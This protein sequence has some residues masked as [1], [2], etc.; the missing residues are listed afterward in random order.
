MEETD[1]LAVL[2]GHNSTLDVDQSQSD[3]LTESENESEPEYTDP[4]GFAEQE[5]NKITLNNYLNNHDQN[6]T[7]NHEENQQSNAIIDRAREYQQELFEK[8]RDENVIAVLD[9][10]SGKTLIAALLIRH[11]L[12]QEL[13]D[14]SRGKSPKIVFFLVNSVHLARQQARFLSNNLPQKVIPLFGDASDALWE[15]AEWDKIFAENGVVVCTAAV[16]DS[17]LMHSYL[18]V[19][20]ISLLVFDEAHHCKKNHPYSR[21]IRDY[22]LKWRGDK[23]RIFGMTASPVDSR[24]DISKVAEDLETLLQS[25]IVTTNDLSVFDFAPRAKDV[26]WIYPPLEAEFET[27]LYSQLKPLCGSFQEFEPYFR[28]ARTASRQLGAWA[29]DRLWQYAFPT[30]EYESTLIL[31][32]FERSKAYTDITENK[33]RGAALDSLREAFSIVQK[34]S[35]E[36]PEVG[37]DRDLSSKVQKLY[38]ELKTRFSHAAT[39]RSIVFVEER[40]TALILC[41]LFESLSLP[42]LRA[43]VLM[44]ITSASDLKSSWKDQE[45]VMEKFR[46]GIINIIFATSVAE[47]GIDIP[48]CNLVIRFDLYRTPIQYMQSRG[49]ARMKGSIFVHMIEEGNQSQEADVNFA[50]DQDEYI[51]KFCQ[52][53]PPDRLLGQGSKL[54]QLMAKDANCRS[55]ETSSGV[56]ANY[57]N[58]LL[59]LSRYA[60]SLKK[61]GAVSS[62]IYEE[63]ID[64]EENMF[65]YRVIL[66]ITD[67]ERTAQVKGAKGEARSNK[68]LAKRSAAWHCLLKLR[69]AHLLDENLNSIFFKAKPANHN[70]KTAVPE[71]KEQYDKKVKP[72]FWIESGATSAMLPTNLFVTHVTVGPKSPSWCTDGLLLL[73]RTPLPDIP[74]FSVFVDDNVEKHVQFSRFIG[75][76][77]VT[78]DQVGALTTFTLRGVFHDFFNKVYAQTSTSMSYWLAPPAKGEMKESFESIVDVD[79]LL[80]AQLQERHRWKSSTSAAEAGQNAEKWC[81]AFVVDPGS[82][83]YRYFTSN[84]LPGKSIWDP[85]PESAKSAQKSTKNTIIEFSDSTWGVRRKH[86]Q[87]IAKMYDSNQPVLNAKVVIAGRNFL[88]ECPKERTRYAMCHIAPQPLELGRISFSVAQTCLLWPSILRRLESYLIVQE[89][90]EK[91]DLSGVPLDLALEAYTQEDHTRAD[92]TETEALILE[93]QDVEAQLGKEEPRAVMNYQRLEF[94]GDSLLKMMTTITVFNRSTC[95]EEGMHCKRMNLLSNNRLCTTASA[96]HYEL[97]RYIRSPDVHWRDTWYPEFLELEKGRLIKV[98][99]KHRKHALGKKTIADVCEAT[100]GACIMSTRHLPTEE[101]FDLGIKAITKL[102]EHSDHA[103]NSWKEILPMY[104]PASWVAELNDPIANDIADKLFTAT[105]YR[106]K[107][108]RLAR[109]AFTHSSD[110]HSPVQNLQRLEFLGDACL[111]WVCIWW[112]FSTNPTRGPQWLTEHKMAMVSNK[113]LAALAVVLGF[114]KLVYANSMGVYDDIARYASKVQEAWEQ[115]DVRADFWTRI[116]EGHVPKVLA[117]LVESYLGAVLVDSSFDYREIEYFFEKHVKWFFEDIEAYDTFANRHPTTYL[118]N[119]LVHE[120]RCR[121]FSLPV[122]ENSVPL[123]TNA[124]RGNDQSEDEGDEAVSGVMVE[125]GLFVHGNIVAADRGRG[126]KHTKVR[127]SKAALK[128][129]GKLKIDEFRRQWGCNCARNEADDARGQEET[130]NRAENGLVGDG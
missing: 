65:Q 22:Y 59:L 57:S 92:S 36:A 115:K 119:L 97:F 14:R 73:T 46:T 19:G 127:V 5:A 122:Q 76:V 100:I 3:Y 87:S 27:P 130:G 74:K 1:K 32:K 54:K 58:S 26:R 69:K 55:F 53:L 118:V 18:K 78:P 43:G 75:P 85:I 123:T 93:G 9:T 126:A 120:F 51:R 90:F 70:A 95:D 37:S 41:D 124:T 125:V 13:I 82:G 72:D 64:V 117:D 33:G 113:F 128:K 83:K 101:K 114:N 50:M 47:E 94:L 21:I 96:P 62:E 102:V 4:D 12:Q 16:L 112:L 40:L 91:L 17:C 24:R 109:S 67:D 116:S 8:A 98:T 110:Q 39:T 89:A 2:E 60:E 42:N 48:Q 103:I 28:F 104:K 31:R 77:A 80:V 23:P 99:D 63:M 84:V 121:K 105:G 86:A 61:V 49:R 29:A 7:P 81:N 45:A 52:Q 106:F 15:K 20:Q 30:S 11:Y 56:L 34:H 79:E 88:I 6:Q 44:G 25:K 107:H 35:F 111:D 66:P 129:L 108:P 38:S 68:I 10:G 71:N